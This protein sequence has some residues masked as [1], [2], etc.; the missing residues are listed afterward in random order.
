MP[1]LPNGRHELFALE[2]AQG[3]TADEAYQLAGYKP[4]RGNAARLKADESISGRVAELQRAAAAQTEATIAGVLSELWAI[5]MADANDL[6]EYRRGCCRYCWGKGHRWQETQGERD[7]REREYLRAVRDAGDDEEK[8]AEVGEWSE[9]GGVGYDARR[10]PHPDCPE[11][12][13][14]GHGEVFVKDTRHLAPAARSLFGGV[15]V[16]KDGIEVRMHDKVS[17]LTKVGQHLGMFPKSVKVGNED[18]KPFETE[19]VIRWAM[20]GEETRRDPSQDDLSE[21]SEP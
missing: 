3:K 14:L 15:K 11:C 6:V 1:P 7:R 9:R 4:N 10:G 13:G 5:G 18:G 21:D 12:F 16:T 8:Q 17:A 2:L 20:E 19:T